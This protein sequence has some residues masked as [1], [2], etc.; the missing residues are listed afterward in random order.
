MFFE[1]KLYDN[2][3]TL[4]YIH[5]NKTNTNSNRTIVTILVSFYSIANRNVSFK[6]LNNY[7]KMFL[8]YL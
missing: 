8:F 5:S 6:F 1:C 2:I 4:V 3:L 7:I